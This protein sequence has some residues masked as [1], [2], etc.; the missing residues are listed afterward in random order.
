M[1][2]WSKCIVPCATSS[3]NARTLGM[4]AEHDK[5]PDTNCTR[6]FTTERT[7][8]DERK[9]CHSGKY[10]REYGICSGYGLH[11]MIELYALCDAVNSAFLLTSFNFVAVHKNVGECV[12]FTVVCH[13]LSTLSPPD[14]YRNTCSQRQFFFSGMTSWT[15]ALFNPLSPEAEFITSRL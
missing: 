2:P 9:P 5:E 8:K 6:V 11:Q 10:V 15:A 12:C 13:P 14:L 1:R 3:R 7:C 4:V